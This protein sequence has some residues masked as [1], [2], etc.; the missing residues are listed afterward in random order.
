MSQSISPHQHT[1]S[2]VM[3]CWSSVQAVYRRRLTTLCLSTQ[4]NQEAPSRDR[5][6][7]ITPIL[8]VTLWHHQAIQRGMQ[9]GLP[10][11][12][13]ALKIRLAD[14]RQGGNLLRR[15]ALLA[16]SFQWVLRS[17]HQ[18]NLGWL[19]EVSCQTL[20]CLCHPVVGPVHRP[21]VCGN[22]YA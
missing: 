7:L 22:S 15:G 11:S 8:Q 21:K 3:R 6:L 5:I 18:Y 2:S 19:P 1:A 12:L 20:R 9:L 17:E 14:G 13:T 10:Q 4:E 16:P